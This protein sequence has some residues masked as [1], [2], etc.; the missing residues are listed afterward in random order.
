MWYRTKESV[1]RQ[2]VMTY[3]AKTYKNTIK[4]VV[5]FFSCKPTVSA[6]SKLHFEEGVECKNNQTLNE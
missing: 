6:I 4:R 5:N 1:K 3:E 2:S